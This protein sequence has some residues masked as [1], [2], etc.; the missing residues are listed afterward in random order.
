[1]TPAEFRHAQDETG[2]VRRGEGVQAKAARYLAQ[3]RLQ[4]LEVG[5][6]IVRA[7]CRGDTGTAHRLGWWRGRWGCPARP[8]RSAGRAYLSPGP[9]VLSVTPR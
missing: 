9:G 6:G 7:T 3:A 1:V 2:R 5:P 4:V 8:P